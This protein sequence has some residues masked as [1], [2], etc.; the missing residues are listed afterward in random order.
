MLAYVADNDKRGT[1]FCAYASREYAISQRK[2]AGDLLFHDD[3]SIDQNDDWLF[4]WE[5]KDENCYAKQ[6][7]R[8]NLNV[9]GYFWFLQSRELS[10]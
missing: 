1:L 9:K 2:V 10:K 3:G 6:Q 8:A 5:K 7:Q 4:E